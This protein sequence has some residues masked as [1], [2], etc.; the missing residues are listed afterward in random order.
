MLM[1]C[2][3]HQ[4]MITQNTN[5]KRREWKG[6]MDTERRFLFLHLWFKAV[7]WM[8]PVG[9]GLKKLLILVYCSEWAAG[10]QAG[11]LWGQEC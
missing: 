4:T 1:L 7:V 3:F 5:N 11:L 8:L 9:V 6:G 2:D 10:Q